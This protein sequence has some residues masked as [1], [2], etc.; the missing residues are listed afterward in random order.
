MKN[1]KRKQ[2]A[3]K[4]SQAYHLDEIAASVVMMQGATT[5]DDLASLVL[6]RDATDLNAMYVNFFHEKI[7][8]RQMDEF[9]PLTTLNSLIQQQPNDAALYRTRA[10]TKIFKNDLLGSARDLTDALLVARRD[11]KAHKHVKLT[12]EAYL[13][14]NGQFRIKEWN[15]E[16]MSDREHPSSMEAHLLFHRA[17]IYLRIACESIEAALRA[18][19]AQTD[20]AAT[21]EDVVNDHGNPLDIN[22][23]N[24]VKQTHLDLRKTVKSNARKALRDYVDFMSHLEY[25]PGFSA[26][27]IEETIVSQRNKTDDLDIAAIEESASTLSL[28]SS[29]AEELESNSLEFPEVFKLSELFSEAP[30]AALPHFPSISTELVKANSPDKLTSPAP[31]DYLLERVSFHPLL[32]EAL[33][34]FLLCHALVQT[35]TTELRR[36]SMNAARI[37]RLLTGYPLFADARST[38]RAD[39]HEVLHQTKDWIGLGQPWTDLSRSSKRMLREDRLR[40]ELEPD[41]VATKGHPHDQTDMPGEATDRADAIARWILEAPQTVE[42]AKTKSKKKRSKPKAT[43]IHET[44][45]DASEMPATST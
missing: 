11:E 27:K 40:P 15:G 45:V 29:G 41:H 38:S 17:G 26:K 23:L 13:N 8:S 16:K 25:T 39:W 10:L 21:N 36:H 14:S 28:S 32:T 34:S 4:L 24:K 31:S 19:S 9:T 7:P 18:W 22:D 3:T 30:L 5:L 35:S 33:H 44:D 43:Q 2:A 12:P 20:L 1:M 37:I 6:Q 42:G